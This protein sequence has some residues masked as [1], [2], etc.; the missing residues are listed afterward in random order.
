MTPSPTSLYGEHKL[1]SESFY[2]AAVKPEKLAII[3]PPLIYSEH[4]QDGY[5]P[6][7]F[8]HSAQTS[9]II[10]LWGDGSEL[11]EFIHVNDAALAITEITTST[12]HGIVN[13]VMG[14]SFSYQEI[15]K[16]IQE[17]KNCRINNQKR[18]GGPLVNH[19]YDG[20]KLR[21]CTRIKKFITPSE[22]IANYYKTKQWK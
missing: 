13:L 11:R 16:E 19:T 8:L 17:I 2:T 22:S 15:A 4:Q 10:N 14:R 1:I 21:G 18:T 20:R 3:R 12:F 9:N 7:G 5:H 6:G